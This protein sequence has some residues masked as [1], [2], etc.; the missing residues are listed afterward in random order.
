MK[1]AFLI[2]ATL[3]LQG[4]ADK[5]LA[6]IVAN[7]GKA[8]K[9]ADFLKEN[10]KKLGVVL[11]ALSPGFAK[12]S[13]TLKDSTVSMRAMNNTFTSFNA[14]LEA[15]GYR[16]ETA[17]GK[18][19]KLKAA[20]AGVGEA[21]AASNT[22]M[23]PSRAGGGGGRRHGG[24]VHAK[25]FHFGAFGFSAPTIAAAGVGFGAY[26]SIKQEAA[27][28]QA[29]AQ[30]QAMNLGATAN[31]SANNFAMNARMPGISRIEMLR[32][33][34][35]ATVIM[36]GNYKEGEQIAPAL[37]QIKYTSNALGYTTTDEDLM[38][39][40]R[41]AEMRGGF[42]NPQEMMDQLSYASQ[43]IAAFGGT[44]T[45]KDM[46]NFMRTGGVAALSQSD[47]TFWLESLPL[48]QEMGGNRF[49]TALMSMYSALGAGRTTTA[50]AKELDRLGLIKKGY[51][52]YNTIGMIKRI[53]PGGIVNNEELSTNFAGFL[54]DTLFPALEKKGIKTASQA[55]LELATILPN[56]TAANLAAQA[57]VQHEKIVQEYGMASNAMTYKQQKAIA[58]KT[59]QGQIAQLHAAASDLGV[60]LGG[61]L[62]PGAIAGMKG[63]TWTINELVSGLQALGIYAAKAMIKAT[64]TVQAW[65]TPHKNDFTPDWLTHYLNKFRHPVNTIPP[66][67]SQAIQVTTINNLDGKEIYRN[68][69]MHAGIQAQ[70]QQQTG[71]NF[72]NPYVSLMPPGYNGR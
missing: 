3:D 19:E 24:G 68:T 67:S 66:S 59:P 47:K 20:M 40:L 61:L 45:P 33:L 29:L 49:G 54:F 50:A 31:S 48:I 51:A 17:I 4:N 52:E 43:G 8:G 64:P 63:L 22:A 15:S 71:P 6:R 56:R 44:V 30:F 16:M 37:A 57:Y 65:A 9:Q 70:R 26:E 39:I 1:D 36:K 72:P 34:R 46:Q 11:D 18:A 5:A 55:K 14:R 2:A 23:M 25:P 58:D 32:L 28:A 62:M 41:V 38:K 35:D 27:Y 7:F 12:L 21:V 60:A 13:D 42:K 10:L 69:T 53:K